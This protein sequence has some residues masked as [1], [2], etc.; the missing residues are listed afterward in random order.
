MAT[1]QVSSVSQEVEISS[2][3]KVETS[4]DS[5]R[6]SKAWYVISPSRSATDHQYINESAEP[7]HQSCVYHCLY[8]YV[9]AA[10]WRRI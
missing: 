10:T 4:R 1:T 9:N 7:C 8:E 5:R 2:A 6:M 3:L